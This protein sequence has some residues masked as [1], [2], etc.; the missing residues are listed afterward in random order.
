MY[1]DISGISVYCESRGQGVP[2]VCLHGYGVDHRS[3][4][5]GM[6]PI[7]KEENRFQ[8]IYF[9]LP[10]MGK[11]APHPQILGSDDMLEIVLQVIDE[12]LG[13]D[14]PFALA[15]YSYGGYLARGVVSQMAH[16]IKGVCLICPV[17]R[18]RREGRKLPEFK[19][20]E[21]DNDFL[22][23]LSPEQ[24]AAIDQF[25]TIQTPTVWEQYMSHIQP[26]LG[27][28]DPKLM[29]QLRDSELTNDPD[30]GPV[31]EGPALI[32]T[33]RYDVAVGYEDA[34]KILH[35]FPDADFLVLNRAGHLLH[36]EQP[37]LF[38]THVRTWLDRI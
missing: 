36:M 35:R 7:L 26:S 16:R 37:D 20:C 34:W 17:I 15:G 10:G 5:S 14:Q 38:N 21:Q 13:P 4:K 24:F 2:L 28:S 23:S 3:I 30:T 33:G 1:I 25:V 6:E 8:R 32:L 11:S 18:V 29:M 31:Y 22:A 9:D 12:L 27:L 19:C